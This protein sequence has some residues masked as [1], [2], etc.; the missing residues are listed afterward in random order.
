[1]TKLCNT[2]KTIKPKNSF[3]KHKRM[4]DGL[5]PKC[6]ECEKKQNARSRQVKKE[7]QQRTIKLEYLNNLIELGGCYSTK[8][9]KVD[10]LFKTKRKIQKRLIKAL[11]TRYSNKS[12]TYKVLQC[13]WEDFIKHMESK[14][15]DGMPWDNRSEWDID[16]IIPF[17]FAK[18]I[19]DLFIL[20]HYSNIQPLFKQDNKTKFTS[21]PE[22]VEEKFLELTALYN[23]FQKI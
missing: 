4:H 1:M 13:P 8:R 6:K 9:A 10:I 22:N 14:F 21:L 17:A 2:C 20:N 11:T 12:F 15:Q 23:N 7:E 3:S 19:K 5:Q 18:S 16:H